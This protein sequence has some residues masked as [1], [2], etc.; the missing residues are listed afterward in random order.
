[1]RGGHARHFSNLLVAALTLIVIAPRGFAAQNDCLLTF[2]GVP[3]A[4]VRGGGTYQCTEC[5]PACDADGVTTSDGMCKFN[6][7]VC[8]N[9]RDG[10]CATGSIKKFN[11]RKVSGKCNV[12][13]LKFTPSTSS[14]CGAF[15]GI[16]VK[17]KKNNNKPGKCKITVTAK[18]STR[19]KQNDKDT[20]TLVCNPQKATVCP[21]T[22][23]TTSTTTTTTTLIVCGDGKKQGSEQCD[24]GNLV[25]NDGCD[26]N[27]TLPACG[28]GILNP[29]N[30]EACDPPCGTGCAGGQL[31]ND[32]CQCVAA[33]VC[34]C[35]T[36]APTRLSFTTTTPL[37][38]NCGSMVSATG[39]VTPLV[40][41][42]L[43]FGGGGDAVPLPATVPDTGQ[44]LTKACCSG[45]QIT[46]AA[47]T[48]ADT[49]SPRTCTSRDCLFGPPLPIPNTAPGASPLSTCIINNI[50]Q[51]AVGTAECS[52]GASTLSLPLTSEVFLFGDLLDGA[53]PERPNVPGIQ[54]C[55]ICSKVCA[56]GANAGLPCA[57]DGDCP[58]S[59]CAASTTCLGGPNHGLACTAGS[60]VLK[61][62][63]AGANQGRGCTMDSECPGSTCGTTRSPYPTS[64]DC[65]PGR[66]QGQPI[67][68]LPIGFALTTGTATDTAQ[69]SGTQPR[70]F[71]GYCRDSDDTF[72][73]EGAPT[74]Q[75]CPASAG[76]KL[77]Q[78]NAD[79]S[80]PY[81]SCEQKTPGAFSNTNANTLTETGVP[82]GAFATGDA[83]KA[84]T[85]VS[86][87]CIPPTFNPAIDAAADLPG[88]GAVSL[89]G[90]VQ[91]LP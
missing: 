22:T 40:C 69:P 58:S 27:C 56:G 19:P 9:R 83:P 8:A 49:S 61:V 50:A 33:S 30:G 43:Y 25:D 52:T 42:G 6:I 41:G 88:P 31:C 21:T 64:H 59:T 90:V 32:Q 68:T 86:V 3:T 74:S 23:T 62:C 84:S 5:D 11:V 66:P 82:S 15:T 72:C 81:E 65:P 57:T 87:F 17:T 75:G 48:V 45:T 79:C 7:R 80:Q 13:G 18:S 37:L 77:C 78:S 85:L 16:V 47:T 71:C 70:V 76:L 4:A 28:N 35:G 34:A 2:D 54:P 12:K 39:T 55:P 26:S 14:A 89:P 20:L 38:G 36:P 44:S 29:G 73:F 51:N 67:G 46:L 91:L 60:S 1:M 63:D 10:G 24:D 53:L